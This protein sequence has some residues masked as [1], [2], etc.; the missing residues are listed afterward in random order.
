[1]SQISP[2]EMQERPDPNPADTNDS[3]EAAGKMLEEVRIAVKYVPMHSAD[4][5][6]IAIDFND[7]DIYAR[8]KENPNDNERG[9]ARTLPWNPNEDKGEIRKLPWSPDKDKGEIRKLPWNPDKDK[10]EAKPLPWN[11]NDG[12]KYKPQPMPWCPGGKDR[13]MPKYI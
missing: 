12:R 1:M 7:R 8:L 10:G 5:N 3:Q 2:L 4:R 9:E 6:Q 13:E 11:P